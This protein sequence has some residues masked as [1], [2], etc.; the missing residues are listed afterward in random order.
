MARKFSSPRTA[1]KERIW[2]SMMSE[3]YMAGSESSYSGVN[4]SLRVIGQTTGASVPFNF[5][6]TGGAGAGATTYATRDFTI[7]AASVYGQQAAPLFGYITALGIQGI[8]QVA[9]L[10]DLPVFGRDNVPGIWPLIGHWIA[11]GAES[12]LTTTDEVAQTLNE[13][14]KGMRKVKLGQALYLSTLSLQSTNSTA[15]RTN[16]FVRLLC[17]L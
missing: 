7:L 1:R 13:R 16:V 10:G 12:T 17:G 8:S 2:V 15:I 4:S 14:S 3:I 9:S 6:S 5:L 11:A